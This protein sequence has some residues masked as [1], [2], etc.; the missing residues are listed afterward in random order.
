M[1]ELVLPKSV[2]TARPHPSLITSDS[3][4]LFYRARGASVDLHI[5]PTR[6][7]TNLDLCRQVLPHPGCDPEAADLNVEVLDHLGV[8]ASTAPN[9]DGFFTS[10][11]CHAASIICA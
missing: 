9:Q 1:S 4:S 8:V 7:G 11:A 5:V 3:N 10:S 2:A 6:E